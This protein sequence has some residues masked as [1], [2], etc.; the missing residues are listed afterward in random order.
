MPDTVGLCV[1]RTGFEFNG[2]H[3]GRC[4][5]DTYA[6]Q[7][8]ALARMGSYGTANIFNDCDGLGSEHWQ[9]FQL[10][11]DRLPRRSRAV[12]AQLVLTYVVGV[13]SSAVDLTPV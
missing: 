5:I 10:T 3:A 13:R 1:D 8:T 7:R 11:L 2:P 4:F 9:V 6:H 12:A